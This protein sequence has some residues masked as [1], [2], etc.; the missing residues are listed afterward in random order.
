MKINIGPYRSFIGPYQIAE[1]LCFWHKKEED[2]Y[3]FPRTPDWVH[4]FGEWLSEDKH[5]ND[6]WITKVCQWVDSKKERKV[7]VRIDP[8]DTWNMDSTL[9][10]IILPMLKQLKD[11][12]DGSPSVDDSDVPDELKSTSAPPLTEEE[13]GNCHTDENWH[14]RWEYVMD[15]MIFAFECLNDNSW[16]DEYRSGEIDWVSVPVDED[17]NECKKEDAKFFRQDDGPNHTYKCDYEG[18]KIIEER[19]EKGTTLF[20]KYYQNLWD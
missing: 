1:F 7:Y 5:G 2:E 11:N 12:K 3:G 20:G 17:G 18:M 14:K 13:I 16:Q 15:E 9:T 8:Y 6:S 4:N 19:I 10:T